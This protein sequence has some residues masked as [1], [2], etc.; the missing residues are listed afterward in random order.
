M[1]KL[2][3]M[4]T[5]GALLRDMRLLSR[6]N[7]K[8]DDM[9]LEICFRKMDFLREDI[10]DKNSMLLDLVVDLQNLAHGLLCMDLPASRFIFRAK[11]RIRGLAL[12]IKTAIRAKL[13]GETD[14]LSF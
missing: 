1:T 11:Y 6:Q 10:E 4:R 2:Y 14:T 13:Y 12:S 9:S 5:H 7:L 3:L 8:S